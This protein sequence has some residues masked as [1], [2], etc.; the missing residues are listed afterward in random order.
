MKTF[1]AF[2]AKQ[3]GLPSGWF[4]QLLLRLL[5][6]SHTAVLSQRVCEFGF[7]QHQPIRAD[8]A[9]S[10]PSA[11]DARAWV[12]MQRV[13]WMQEPVGAPESLVQNQRFR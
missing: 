11:T 3:L 9:H 8:G 13:R 4:G 7:R 2:L 10:K 12:P 5:N 6:R 1:R